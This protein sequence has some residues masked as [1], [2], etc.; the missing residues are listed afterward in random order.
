M[1]FMSTR[2]YYLGHQNQ[3]C[4]L[5]SVEGNQWI[6]CLLATHG[7][8]VTLMQPSESVLI[9]PLSL[10]ICFQMFSAR[11]KYNLWSHLKVLIKLRCKKAMAHLEMTNC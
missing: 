6:A 5:S 7:K 8:D 3:N 11:S 9:F 10:C 4:H 2:T 1:L